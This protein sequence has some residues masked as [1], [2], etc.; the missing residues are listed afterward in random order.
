M[1]YRFLHWNPLF[2]IDF[3][4]GQT[5]SGLAVGTSNKWAMEMVLGEVPAAAPSGLIELESRWK[6]RITWRVAS[7]NSGHAVYEADGLRKTGCNTNSPPERALNASPV[8]TG[9]QFI[10]KWTGPRLSPSFEPQAA[11]FRIRRRLLHVRGHMMTQPAR[12][13]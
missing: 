2:E 11:N 12:R 4:E 10:A 8:D 1:R 7:H 5:V 3:P 6:D 13:R 9:H